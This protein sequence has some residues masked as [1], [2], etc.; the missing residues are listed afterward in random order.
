[1]SKADEYREILRTLDHWDSYLLKES[2]LPGPRGNLELAQVVADKG[3]LALFQRYTAYTADQAPINSPYEFLAFC[4]VV[5]L[6]R[7]IAEDDISFLKHLRI[8]ASDSRWRIREAVAMA[9]QRFGCVNMDQLIAEMRVWSKG[10]PLEQRAVAAALCEPKLLKEEKHA[11][12]VLAILDEI[13]S[14]IEQTKNRRSSDF[15]VLRKGLGYCWSVA[16]VALPNE[17][18]ALMEKWLQNS[19]KDIHWIMQENLKKKRLER[20]DSIWVDKWRGK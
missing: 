14:T 8:F 19:D 2:G 11:R 1:M 10:T 16:I 13:T 4:G 20:M 9:L 7:L 5:G 6:G 15:L 18:K 12:A 17:G 3:D